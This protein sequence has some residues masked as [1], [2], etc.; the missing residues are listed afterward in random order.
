MS[1]G[2]GDVYKRQILASV[3]NLAQS[4][5]IQVTAEGVETKEQY[6]LLREMNVDFIQ[7]YY[8]AK[9]MPCSEYEE[10]VYTNPGPERQF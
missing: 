5:D 7:G 3:I 9:P 6:D 1:R 2:L 8:C 10:L 4:L